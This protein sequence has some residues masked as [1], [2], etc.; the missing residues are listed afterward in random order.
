MNKGDL[1]NKAADIIAAKVSGPDMHRSERLKANHRLDQI[2]AARAIIA[3]CQA[4][5]ADEIARLREALSACADAPHSGWTIAQG[6]ARAALQHKEP[7][8]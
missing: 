2:E 1:V 3:I 6:L 8:G 7:Q 4:E 5:A